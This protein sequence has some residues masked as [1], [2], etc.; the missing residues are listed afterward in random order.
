MK[1]IKPQ[2]LSAITRP[3][4]FTNTYY[5]GVTVF[6]LWDFQEGKPIAEGEQA[7]WQLFKDESVDVFGAEAL[8]MGIPKQQADLILNAYGYGCYAQN[9]RT[10]V[11]VQLNNVKKSLWVT[12]DRYWVNNRATEPLPFDKIAI[13]WRNAYGGPEL[14]ENC[15]GKG[16]QVQEF[17]GTMVQFLPNIEDPKNPVR[18]ETST[19]K[20]AG[21]AAIPIEYP[22]RHLMMGTYDET[23][24][25]EEYPGFARDI[26]WRY[27]N[28]AQPD[29]YLGRLRAGDT[30]RFTNMHPTKPQLEATI[31]DW[32]VRAFVKTKDSGEQIAGSLSP[33]DFALTTIWAYPHKEQAVLIYQ[34]NAKINSDDGD[35]LTHMMYALEHPQAT[36]SIA[37]YEQVFQQRI[38]P[39]LGVMYAALDKQLVDP[40]YMRP[41]QI[42]QLPVSSNLQNKM[43]LLEAELAKTQAKV[44]EIKKEYPLAEDDPDVIKM[45]ELQE[46]LG[47]G[48]P[49]EAMDI[50][51]KMMSGE[52]GFEQ[53]IEWQIEQAKK[54]Q[55]FSDKRRLLRE[56]LKDVKAKQA[57]M[58]YAEQLEFLEEHEADVRAQ[59]VL[60]YKPKALKD[61][62]EYDEEQLAKDAVDEDARSIKDLRAIDYAQYQEFDRL[63]KQQRLPKTDKGL[64]QDISVVDEHAALETIEN[65]SHFKQTLRH[66]PEGFVLDNG[67]FS[68]EDYTQLKIC[69]TFIHHTQFTQCGFK[70]A[71]L[72]HCRF[73]HVV[74]QSCDFEKADLSFTVFEDCHFIDC[75]MANLTSTRL[76]LKR[77]EF[78]HCEL[79]SWMHFKMFVEQVRFDECKFESFNFFRARIQGLHFEQCKLSRQSFVNAWLRQVS[80]VQCHID[81]M[82]MT[83]TKQIKQ[84]Q[85]KNSEVEKFFIQALTEVQDL[86]VERSLM[87]DSCWRELI[88]H[89]AQFIEADIG[90]NEFSKTQFHYANFKTVS[91]KDSLFVRSDFYGATIQN[92]DFAQTICKSANFSAAKLVHV[93]FFCAELALIKTDHLTIQEDCWLERANVYPRL[94]A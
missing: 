45:R 62:G 68:Q 75:K 84:L 43:K 40:E 46:Q 76:N 15:V 50:S 3:Y 49:D 66:I 64:G 42:E 83:G 18:Y 52:L 57:T 53:M 61:V 39:Q 24:R 94:V 59:E 6:V 4:Q 92:A 9:G 58:S 87:K 1:T 85:I 54:P 8:D 73:K 25:R 20:P 23:W 90:R 19:Y 44:D 91:A 32:E 21:F 33:V 17:N 69:P 11:E 22:N 16:H 31:P 13:S 79:T 12:G 34:A 55:D 74:F 81:S 67:Y 38:D 82:S 7:L 5:L 71:D 77:V 60:A 86:L 36:K 29:Q 80:F 56:Q 26:D 41:L 35:E 48:D 37:Y 65:L 63:R 2:R 78:T 51:R 70:E 14:P 89:Q 27:F 30:I 88:L 47:I 72:Q 93:S 28:Q 10:A